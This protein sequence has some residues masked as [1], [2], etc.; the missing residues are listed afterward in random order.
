LKP[1]D[2]LIQ[3]SISADLFDPQPSDSDEDRAV[4]EQLRRLCGGDLTTLDSI[5]ELRA[6][7]KQLTRARAMS[8]R[9]SAVL[10]DVGEELA[11]ILDDLRFA[12][13]R[14]GR[15]VLYF[16]DW[17]ARVH[18]VIRSQPRFCDAYVMANSDREA[19]VI[20]GS[21]P[22]ED[23]LRDLRSIIDAHPPRVQVIWEVTVA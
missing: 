11:E 10:E 2:F 12:K 23:A 14:K 13:S 20:S 15:F 6:E 21:V 7:I 19:V 22:D 5:K 3:R 8:D 1:S 4:L 16:Q 17:S 9:V 18:T